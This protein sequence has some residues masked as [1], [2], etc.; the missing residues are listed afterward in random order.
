MTL[1][2]VMSKTEHAT[3]QVVTVTVPQELVEDVISLVLGGGVVIGG[4]CVGG[5]SAEGV[6]VG[7]FSGGGGV[8]GGGLFGGPGGNVNVRGGPLGGKVRVIPGNP[9]KVSIW[10]GP[11]AGKVSVRGGPAAGSVIVGGS[12]PGGDIDGGGFP[13]DEV[14]EVP[15]EGITMGGTKDDEVVE[16]VSV[17][18][19]SVAVVC[20]DGVSV[21]LLVPVDDVLVSLVSIDDVSVDNAV[22]DDV[23][24]QLVPDVVVSVVLELESLEPDCDVVSVVGRTLEDDTPDVARLDV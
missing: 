11:P 7:G 21:A 4:P 3:E 24:A 23:L 16:E 9:G 10:G 18:V 5:V 1:S 19:V 17:E 12:P 6:S 15:V 13:V 8:V 20:V 22:V 2:A 14:D